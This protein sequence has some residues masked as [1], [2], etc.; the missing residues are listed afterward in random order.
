MN[1]KELVLAVAA[2]VSA[3]AEFD[4]CPC[5][6]AYMALGCDMGKWEVVRSV[7]VRAGFITCTP[8]TYRLTEKGKQLAEEI[9][10]KMATL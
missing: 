3:A 8:S 1:Q 9:N 2:V 10:A 6:S 5:T 7:C 4:F